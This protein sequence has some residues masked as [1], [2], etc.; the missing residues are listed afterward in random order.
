MSRR[1]GAFFA[2]LV[3]GLLGAACATGVRPDAPASPPDPQPII[4]GV[5][6]SIPPDP[7]TPLSAVPWCADSSGHSSVYP[8]KWDARE[9]AP[10]GWDPQVPQVAI[11]VL[12]SPTGCANVPRFIRI[13]ENNDVGFACY[14]APGS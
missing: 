7:R 3:A 6:L 12:R 13:S 14:Y 11:W 10:V 8:C 2:L 4:S 5:R 9:R 1:R